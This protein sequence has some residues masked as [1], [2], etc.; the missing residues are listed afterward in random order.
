MSA[1]DGD[2]AKA[3]AASATGSQKAGVAQAMVVASINPRLVM[4]SRP[5]LLALCILV[6]TVATTDGM[7]AYLLSSCTTTRERR[8]TT[9][10]GSRREHLELFSEALSLAG[11]EENVKTDVS[12]CLMGARS[13]DTFAHPN[14]APSIGG[15]GVVGYV[16]CG[17]SDAAMNDLGLVWCSATHKQTAI[18]D[19]TSAGIGC[20]QCGDHI[21][22]GVQSVPVQALP[23]TLL[24]RTSTVR[25]ACPLPWTAF[26]VALGYAAYF[27]V[28][29]TL[30][31]VFLLKQ[32]GVIKIAPGSVDA[33][34]AFAQMKAL[35]SG[36]SLGDQAR[37]GGY[38]A[39][40]LNA[41]VLPEA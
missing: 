36:A 1:T 20:R 30:L 37:L 27:E 28:V 8:A 38:R 2:A 12:I 25:E 17:V 21:G 31:F 14:A 11:V 33:G 34:G 23:F 5:G 39:D 16:P 32:T 41:S 7:F 9:Q 24:I 26:G 13:L 15:P 22:T 19:C 10:V 35:A 40:R 4:Y 6:A 18:V 29:A 3:D